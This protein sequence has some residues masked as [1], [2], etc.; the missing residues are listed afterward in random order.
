MLLEKCFENALS[1]LN[2]PSF[3]DLKDRNFPKFIAAMGLSCATGINWIDLFTKNQEIEIQKASIGCLSNVLF[4]MVTSMPHSCLEDIIMQI[5][6]EFA[7]NFLTIKL[8][9]DSMA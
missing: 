3:N 5:E 4:N 2:Q 6:K 1:S 7:T 8:D 9:S